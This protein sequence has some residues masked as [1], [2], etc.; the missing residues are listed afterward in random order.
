M[1]ET[2]KYLIHGVRSGDRV[3][4]SRAI[5]LMESK[6][7]DHQEQALGMLEALLPQSGNS[8]R[9]G[10]TGIP[11]VGKSTFINAFGT[12]LTGI[13]KKVAVLS[14]DPSSTRTKGSILGDK[15]RMDLLSRDPNAF[16]RPSPSANQL[17][18]VAQK[19]RESILLCEAAG[20]DVILVE[21]VG[22]GQSETSVRNMVDFFLLLLLARGG[23]ELQGIKRGIMEMA[24][25][26]L[27]NKVDGDNKKAGQLAQKEYQRALHLFPPKENSWVIPVE[28]VSSIEVV[29]IEKTWQYVQDFFDQTKKSGYFEKERNE[30]NAEW[31]DEAL[32]QKLTMEF[33]QKPG[34]KEKVDQLRSEISKGNLSVRAA[35]NQLFT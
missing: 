19:T 29:G 2:L 30:Q 1:N 31:L 27:I 11:G 26:L 10:I 23:D 34:M 18:G 21:T 25:M 12:Y 32:N 14:V 17:G 8:I 7:P 28:T 9:I 13:G 35:I 20:F 22:V 3:A 33:Y 5:T 6:K 16:I 24:D 15:T 4:L